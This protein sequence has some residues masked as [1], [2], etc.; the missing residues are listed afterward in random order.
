MCTI[1][2]VTTSSNDNRV[3]TVL[4]SFLEGYVT[5]QQLQELLQDYMTIAFIDEGHREIRNNSLV[6]T[7]R[8]PVY[9]DH[10][11]RILHQYISGQMLDTDLSNWAA[12]IFLSEVFVPKGETEEER[13]QAGEGAVWD[14]LQRLM[15]PKI[16]DNLNK[17]VAQRYVYMLADL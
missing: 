4:R 10:L 15:T 8:I 14:I 5:L 9:E 11:R 1:K 6:G 3:E 2:S 17:Q 13:W 16:F 12:M 7:I